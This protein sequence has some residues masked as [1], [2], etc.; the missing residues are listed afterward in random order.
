MLLYVLESSLEDM[1]RVILLLLGC[2]VQCHQKEHFVNIITQLH[3]DTQQAIVE[4]I[5]E[6][7]YHILE[8]KIKSYH[9]E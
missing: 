7:K 1:K 5:K 4:H 3:I 6:V 8:I 2:A 9:H